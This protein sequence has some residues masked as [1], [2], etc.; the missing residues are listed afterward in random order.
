ME[1][2]LEMGEFIVDLPVRRGMPDRVGGLADVVKSPEFAT[3]VGL[4][5]YGL[6]QDK[7]NLASTSA[8]A[9]FQ[10]AFTDI[11]QRVKEFFGGAL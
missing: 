4:L 1:G 8:D 10:E 7:H 2:M 3:A 6:D 9:T 5:M 11:A